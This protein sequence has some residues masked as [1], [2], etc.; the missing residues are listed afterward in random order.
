MPIN[1][2]KQWLLRSWWLNLE[3][4][5]LDDN[6]RMLTPRIMKLHWYIDHDSQMKLWWNFTRMFVWTISR[7]SLTLCKD[8]MNRLLSGERT[9]AILALLLLLN[10]ATIYIHVYILQLNYWNL[11]E[12][13]YIY[14]SIIF[15]K[16]KSTKLIKCKWPYFSANSYIVCS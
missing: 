6:S 14:V 13:L 8:W 11:L 9:R 5:F 3:K 7:S 2:F 10:M 16:S 15:T 1:I 12:K 4:W